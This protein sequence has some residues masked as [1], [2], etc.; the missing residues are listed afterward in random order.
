M[1]L[2]DHI[3][4]RAEAIQQQLCLAGLC[5]STSITMMGLEEVQKARWFKC[6]EQTHTLANNDSKLTVGV[7][8]L[9][10]Q[11]MWTKGH[12]TR[13]ESAVATLLRTEH[14]GFNASLLRRPVPGY[15]KPGCKCG[16]RRK[17]KTHP[18]VL[19]CACTGA[20]HGF[21]SK[22]KRIPQAATDWGKF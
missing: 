22:D 4:R 3:W 1:R 10:T 12:L 16:W 6:Q 9:W 18:L 21:R 5:G 14:T 17:S 13:A 11:G 7:H 8:V 20:R 2:I 15:P 19:P